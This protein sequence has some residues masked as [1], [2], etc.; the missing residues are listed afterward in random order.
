M[1]DFFRNKKTLIGLGVIALLV[2]FFTMMKQSNNTTAGEIYEIETATYGDI[3]SVVEATGTVRAYQS[4][5]LTWKTSGIVETLNAQLDSTAQA[6]DVLAILSK[7]SLSQEIIQ[8]EASLI[9]AERALGDLPTSAKT[10][11]ANAAIAIEDAKEAYDDAVNY[12]N[13][14]DKEVE[15]KVFDGFKRLQTPWG[16]FRIPNFL[17]IKYFPND[18]QKAEAEQDIA[19]QLAA[20]EDAQRAYD[21]V[22]DGPDARD[23]IAAEAQILA[24]QAVLNQAKL[25]SPFSGV[26]TEMNVQAG[27]QVTAGAFAFRVDNLSSLLI[28]LDISEIDINSVSIGQEVSM[29]F[30]A[31]EKKEYTGKVLSVDRIGTNTAGSVNF[32][33]TIEITNPD[34]LVRQGMTAAVNIQVHSV[35]NALLVPNEAVRMLDNKRSVYVLNTDGTLRTA[36]VVLGIRSSVYSEVIGGNLSEGDQI[37][38]N[39]PAVQKLDS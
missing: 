23:V 17:E 9:A 22:K 24:A 35:E 3:A 32:K 15:Y 11:A 28:E 39:P 31:I 19:V 13:L 16:S 34:D 21:R 8:A 38:L 20:W 5:T 25:S 30:D 27:D 2:I 33:A 12:R 18:Q 10:E 36:E 37:V 26:I 4:V 7:D 14:L 6:G 1:K 29:V